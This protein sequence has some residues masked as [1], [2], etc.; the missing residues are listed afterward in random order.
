MGPV[1]G[2]DATLPE[3]VTSRESVRADP[4]VLVLGRAALR[5]VS[6][7]KGSVADTVGRR[8]LSRTAPV[9]HGEYRSHSPL[10]LA[11]LKPWGVLQALNVG[12][13]LGGSMTAWS[14]PT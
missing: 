4:K 11:L 14:E 13:P 3:S 8:T 9:R 7:T 10:N 2:I 5:I 6:E 1:P 12:S